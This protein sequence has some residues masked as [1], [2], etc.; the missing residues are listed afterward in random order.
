MLFPHVRCMILLHYDSRGVNTMDVRNTAVESARICH[1]L[2]LRQGKGLSYC[3]VLSVLQ[4]LESNVILK[5]DKKLPSADGIVLEIFVRKNGAVS[6]MEFDGGDFRVLENAAR[7]KALRLQVVSEELG[8]ALF[9]PDILGV[10]IRSDLRFLVKRVQNWYEKYGTEV[11]LPHPTVLNAA[12]LPDNSLCPSAE[13]EEAIRTALTFPFTYIWGAPGTGKTRMVLASCVISC[14]KRGERVLVAAPTNNALEQTLFGLLPV[15]EREG[16]SLN[17]AAVRLGSPSDEFRDAYTGLCEYQALNGVTLRYNLEINHLERERASIENQLTEFKNAEP[18]GSI[19]DPPALSAAEKSALTERL[20]NVNLR[21]KNLDDRLKRT[22]RAPFP[23]MEVI[24]EFRLCAATMDGCIRCMFPGCGFDPDHIFL[25]EAGYCS[26]IK[27]LT[28]TA[29]HCPV[30]LLGDHMQLPP[31][32]ELDF[33]DIKAHPSLSLWAL[34]ALFSDAAFRA[35]VDDLSAA[36]FTQSSPPFLSLVKCDLNQT[37]RFGPSL[38]NVL[39]RTVYSPLFRGDPDADTQIFAVHVRDPK[40]SRRRSPGEAA[41]CVRYL[42]LFPGESVG[43]I[44]P[45]TGQLRLLRRSMKKIFEDATEDILTVHASQGREWDTVI[46][47][48]VDTDDRYFT[49]S[50]RS[51]GLRV[52]N[53]AVSRARKKLVIICDTGYWLRQK[54]QMLCRLIE[55]AEFLDLGP[56]TDTSHT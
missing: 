43:I 27:G 39:A 38:A 32:F 36:L 44:T 47:S 4:D 54:D 45:Y 53:T 22:R 19:K 42:N 56:I 18:T 28:L 12:D 37:H 1:E 16:I 31:V 7:H 55:Q 41:A 52:I 48:A 46:F 29:W 50:S 51:V 24:D 11:A 25:D 23:I 49:D 33:R 21:I 15:L 5:T 40:R 35:S 20:N 26:L 10:R 30:T 9:D 17:G 34:S 6:I 14:L 13:Q 2:L 8:K 3:T